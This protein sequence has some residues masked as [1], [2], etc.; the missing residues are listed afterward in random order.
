MSTILDANAKPWRP[1]YRR[2]CCRHR[3]RTP[4]NRRAALVLRRMAGLAWKSPRPPLARWGSARRACLR[5]QIERR[6]CN[7]AISPSAHGSQEGSG[8]A[9]YQRRRAQSPHRTATLPWPPATPSRCREELKRSC[10]L[11]RSNQHTINAQK[12]HHIERHAEGSGH[13]PPNPAGAPRFRDGHLAQQAGAVV[14]RSHRC[15]QPAE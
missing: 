3:Q 14:R 2:C 15:A 4:P 9:A 1:A 12:P 7:P 11:A 13:A 5:K 10:Q 8:L 6:V